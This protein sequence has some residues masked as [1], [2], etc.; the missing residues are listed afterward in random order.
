MIHRSMIFWRS[1]FGL[2]LLRGGRG[3]VLLV[4]GML[5]ESGAGSQRAERGCRHQSGF[6]L[7]SP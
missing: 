2:R 6:Q 1:V 3:L 7:H 4:A 5:G